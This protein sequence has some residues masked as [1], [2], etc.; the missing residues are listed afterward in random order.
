MDTSIIT[1]ETLIPVGSLI[2]IVGLVFWLARMWSDVENVKKRQDSLE[3]RI[4]RTDENVGDINARLIRL[5]TKTD[6]VLEKIDDL[7]K[8]LAHEFVR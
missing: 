1:P 3:A 5:E 8:N 7:K 6:A 2:S 4:N